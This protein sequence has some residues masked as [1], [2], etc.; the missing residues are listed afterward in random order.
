MTEIILTKAKTVNLFLNFI[1][2]YGM[3]N[4]EICLHL[5]LLNDSF[6]LEVVQKLDERRHACGISGMAM[7]ATSIIWP[8]L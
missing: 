1:L 6:P 7:L 5:F 2:C 4:V 8:C 3:C